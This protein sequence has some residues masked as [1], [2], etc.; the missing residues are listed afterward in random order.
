MTPALLDRYQERIQYYSKASQHNKRAYKTARYLI[1]VLGG[2]VT[3]VG[4]TLLCVFRQGYLDRNQSE[5]PD[6]TPGGWSDHGWRLFP[7]LSVGRRV[8]RYANRRGTS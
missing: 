8:V 2:L 6:A 5:R 7:E 1:V 3:A 4:V